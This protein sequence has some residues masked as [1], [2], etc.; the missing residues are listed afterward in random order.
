MNNYKI[1]KNFISDIECNELN[2]FISTYKSTPIFQDANMGGVRYTTRYTN[3]DFFSYPK[4]SYQIQKRIISILNLNSYKLPP[5]KD[6]MVVSHALPNDTC[7]EH[8]DPQWYP[9]TKTL[10]CNVALTSFQGGEPL[11]EGESVKLEKGDLLCY[12]VSE[13]NHGSDVILGSNPRNLW[14]FGFSI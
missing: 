9:N 8:K 11:I 2:S 10:H 1:Y 5:Y 4:L 14:I 3:P 7:Y 6:G 13:V 12:F